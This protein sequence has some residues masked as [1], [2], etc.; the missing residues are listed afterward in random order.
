MRAYHRHLLHTAQPRSLVHLSA[1]SLFDASRW[2]GVLR[3]ASV[4]WG[5]N[6]RK[7]RPAT[8]TENSIMSHTTAWDQAGERWKA[9]GEVVV[10]EKANQANGEEA[11][12]VHKLLK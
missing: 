10:G 9:R 6:P 11:D 12:G 2:G 5:S 8:S 3:Y 4:Q 1:S 7:V